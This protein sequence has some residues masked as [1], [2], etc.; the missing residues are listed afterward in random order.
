[1]Y[2]TD[3]TLHILMDRLNLILAQGRMTQTTIDTIIDA[4]KKFD[5]DDEDDF[6]LRAKLAIYL[7][8]TTPEYLIN[9]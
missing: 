8:M 9:R 5:Q 6:E 2:T 4:L 3:E 7:T 1:M